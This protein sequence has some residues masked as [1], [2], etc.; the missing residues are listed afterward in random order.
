LG[1]VSKLVGE[2]KAREIYKY[3][4]KIEEVKM[5]EWFN[6]D[7]VNDLLIK[8]MDRL[9]TLERMG[10]EVYGSVLVLIPDDKRKPVLFATHGK[11]FY[12]REHQTDLDVE[13]AVKSSLKH[14]QM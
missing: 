3:S 12:P 8:L 11:P 1:R 2:A 7:E 4:N 13:M 10:E 6:D 14:R 5:E 9:C